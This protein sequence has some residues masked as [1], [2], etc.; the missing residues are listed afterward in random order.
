MTL[1]L[2]AIRRPFLPLLAIGLCSLMG[3]LALGQM[4]LRHLPD[5]GHDMVE[6]RLTAP[7]LTLSDTDLLLARP[8][9]DSV[10]AIAGIT[11]VG[12]TV[13]PGAVTLSLPLA[14]PGLAD[15]VTT[16]LRD[17]L[18]ALHGSIDV[19]FDVTNLAPRSSR[20]SL[21][22]RIA[23]TAPD[24]AGMEAIHDRLL[25]ALHR[26]PG[27]DRLQ[28]DGLTLPEL[29]LTPH[30][31][32][33]AELG[34]T[35]SDL[36]A[37]L[38]DRLAPAGGGRI[39]SATEGTLSIALIE[40]QPDA[41]PE[42]LGRLPVTLPSGATIALADLAEIRL[43]HRPDSSRVRLDGMPAVL[44]AIHPQPRA[45]LPDLLQRIE[46]TAAAF[47][48]DHGIATRLI[49]RRADSV[50]AQARAT[51]F[52]LLEGALLVL[53]VVWAALRSW[54]SV[55]LAMIV[56]PLSLLPAL[57][58]M[59]AF[60]FSLNIITLMALTLATGIVVDDAI[61][62]VENIHRHLALGQSRWQATLAATRRIGRA[63]IATTLAIVAV[64][65][66]VALIPGMA[67]RYFL[68]FGGTIAIAALASLAVVRL[69][70]PPLAA[71]WIDTPARPETPTTGAANLTL[72]PP[73]PR[74]A[75]AHSRA[76]TLSFRHPLLVMLATVAL[77]TLSV[78]AVFRA[79]GDFIP[80]E[81][82]G[83]LTFALELPRADDA[84]TAEARLATLTRNLLAL[85]GIRHAAAIRPEEDP[86][87]L[88]LI[89]D[90]APRGDRAPA[91]QIMADVQAF[92][93]AEPDLR[94][95]P[96]GETGRPQAEL[97]LT[98]PDPVALDRIA[99]DTAAAL[100]RS[101]ALPN[102]AVDRALI[103]EQRLIL[104]PA[105][106]DALALSRDEADR[107]LALLTRSSAPLARLPQL[108]RAGLPLILD[109]GPA[110]SLLLHAGDGPLLPLAAVTRVELALTPA[111]LDRQDGQPVLRVMADRAEG[112][113]AA[114]ARAAL[115]AAL[116][117]TEA[118]AFG[119]QPLA[120]GDAAQRGDL[121]QAL[122]TALASAL[123]LLAAV[124]FALYRSVGQV[125]VILLTLPLA[126]GGAMMG[127]AAT[128][129]GLSLPA[130]LAMLLLLGIV[131]KNAILIVDEGLSRIA[132]G[133]DAAAAL[134]TAARLRARPVLMTSAAIIGGM[135]PSLA[136]WGEGAGFRQPLAIAVI[137][138]TAVSTLLSLLIVP[139]LSL[140]AH[141][142]GAALSTRLRRALPA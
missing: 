32:R 121:M 57:L 91:T 69:V 73:P 83:R 97:L 72:P 64:F 38:Q 122:K 70:L 40:P 118:A 120:T 51:T 115:S 10:T 35:Q 41:T 8:A 104:D 141:R 107:S 28:A 31:A 22:A 23:L 63:V 9:E 92:L 20:Q 127:L 1:A 88:R 11:S 103:P 43:A 34:L 47:S 4:P 55:A 21:A 81:D 106:T 44:I 77:I 109:P 75:R 142:A 58:A 19:A 101:G 117:T 112:Q 126:L 66:P 52:A 114:E 29:I 39:D 90:L 25:P 129:Q 59:Q 14:D 85:D 93:A 82:T 2:R 100:H 131:A 108:G 3:V 16:D 110:R 27:V 48:R 139:V 124:L 6:A 95:R 26:L 18:A 102:A 84:A 42:A 80:A 132:R 99:A 13:T 61:V 76:L 94:A 116:A 135:L 24:A 67:G 5:I 98:G 68:E 89:L 17:R 30:P 136:G 86:T 105:A 128:G 15:T 62:E 138:G 130:I 113:G 37:A 46:A 111:R 74:L 119:I 125:L 78:T 87:R 65:L 134:L 36:A 49:D 79:E 96:L 45:D 54:R 56:L 60:G 33:L 140:Y 133:E 123:L 50:I 12:V 137:S 7:G 53:A 71:R